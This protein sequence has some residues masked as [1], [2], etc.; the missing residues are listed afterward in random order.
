MARRTAPLDGGLLP[1]LPE[2]CQANL[3]WML[4]PVELRRT[5]ADARGDARRDWVERVTREWGPCGQVLLDADGEPHAHVLYAPAAYLPG[6]DGLATAPPSR[7]AVVLVEMRRTDGAAPPAAGRVL[8][9]TM[10][11]DL[12]AR[13]VAAVETFADVRGPDRCGC[14][15]TPAQ[16][17]E[18][19][20]TVAREHPLHPRMRMDLRQTLSWKDE[21]EQALDRFRDLVR[22]APDTKKATRPVTRTGR[23]RDVVRLR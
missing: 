1:D 23:L 21:V 20:F 18:V 11:K 5:R 19:G 10:A 7:D 15:W 6:L 16:M 17:G 22:P 12:V 13:R 2:D 4:G 8:V 14:R 3:A 9:Q